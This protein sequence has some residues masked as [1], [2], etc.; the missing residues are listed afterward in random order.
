MHVSV[1]ALRVFACAPTECILTDFHIDERSFFVCVQMRNTINTRTGN[2][3]NNTFEQKVKV[4]A[5]QS[6][7]FAPIIH[8]TYPH[9]NRNRRD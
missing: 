9:F 8:Y 5:T 7:I 3:N 6:N 2:C 4:F 1:E